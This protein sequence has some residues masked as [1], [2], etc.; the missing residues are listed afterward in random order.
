MPVSARYLGF[1]GLIPVIF[2]VLL[3]V[4][5]PARDIQLIATA[6]T[7][8]YGG[9]ILSFIGGAWWG[10]AVKSDTGALTGW[11][12]ASVLPS[13]YAWGV[14]AIAW[15]AAAYMYASLMMAAGFVFALLVDRRL[16]LTGQAPAWW[17]RLRNPLS[18]AMGLLFL[19]LAGD[20]AS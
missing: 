11:L 12:I 16:S 18:A 13:L 1:S 7:L 14:V 2:G 5:H 10:L 6:V 20:A 15:I 8:A 9:I 17:M 3:A 4:F 19:A